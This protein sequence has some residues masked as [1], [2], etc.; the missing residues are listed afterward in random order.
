ME[1]VRAL[2]IVVLM[3]L[4][5]AA[6]AMEQT[7]QPPKTDSQPQAYEDLRTLAA[8]LLKYADGAD[9]HKGKCKLL[10]ANFLLPD[11]HSSHYGWQLANDLSHELANQDPSIQVI[12]RILLQSLLEKERIPSEQL[13][14]TNERAVGA[15]LGATA[16][17]IGTTKRLDER[18]VELSARMLSVSNKDHIGNSAEVNLFA[19]VSSTDL[20]PSE[21][22]NAL[23]PLTATSNGEIVYRSGTNGVSLPHCTYMPNPPYSSRA[24]K[25]KISGSLLVEGVITSK[26]ELED[27]RIVRGLPGGMNEN[28]LATLKIWR[29]DPAL[30][31]DKPVAVVVPFEINFRLY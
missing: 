20:S 29:C 24:R 2:G 1:P 11:K 28:A 3:V 18:T 13:S 19:P 23:P 14:E 15:D 16:V 10:V 25:F 27:L 4:C 7:L 9:C 17:L 31:G 5:Y 26:G 22:Y 30:K 8:R 21:P 12:D 6:P